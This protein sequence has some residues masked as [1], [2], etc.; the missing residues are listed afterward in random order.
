M[1]YEMR[2]GTERPEFPSRSHS[3]R[4]LNFV[5]PSDQNNVVL[6]MKRQLH[7]V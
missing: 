4:T 3:S 1:T 5:H 2:L 7:F 6:R